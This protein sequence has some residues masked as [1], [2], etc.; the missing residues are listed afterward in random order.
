MNIQVYLVMGGRGFDGDGELRLATTEQLT[1]GEAEW[2]QS[3]NL[4]RALWGLRA[5]S[6]GNIVYLTGQAMVDIVILTTHQLQ[7]NRRSGR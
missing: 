4:P 5:A 6:L 7:Y 1:E 2:T 3:E